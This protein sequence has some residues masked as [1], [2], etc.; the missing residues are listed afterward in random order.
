M[1]AQF[2]AGAAAADI[3]PAHSQFLYGYP[4]VKRY[5]TG[6]HDP[7]RTAAL[8]LTDGITEAMFVSNDI[9]YVPVDVAR[10]IRRGIAQATGVPAEHVMVT[11][12]H[13]HSGPKMGDYLSNEADPAVP[14]ADPRYADY[15]IERAVAVGTEA[16]RNAT[17]ARA[18]LAVADAAGI[19]TNRRDPR[20]PANARAPVLRVQRTDGHDI[21][22]MLVCSMHPTVLH[23]DSTLVSAD[24]P[25]FARR[26]IEKAVL[27]SPC[28]V[29][30]H[31]GPSGNQS[32]RHSV[33]AN[34]FSE[35]QRLGCL[36]GRAV[37]AVAGSIEYRTDLPI[38]CSRKLLRLP[39]RVFPGV[40]Q[41][42]A[43]LGRA[44][45]RLQLLRKDGAPRAV[46]RTAECDWFG[47]EETLALAKAV[48]D[49]RLD[50]VAESV[51]PAE[52]Q[53]ISLGPW[54]FVGWPGEAFIEYSLMATR[55]HD[56]VFI[57]SL[58]NGELQGYIVTPE[59]AEE[60]GYEASNALFAPASGR[61]LVEATR[62]L[63]EE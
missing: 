33:T 49:G 16:R 2:R 32:P 37:E 47:A 24:F 20:G 40:G 25:G 3:T 59:A 8:Y 50:R 7:L 46:V 53:L 41:A 15:L 27:N 19:G 21:A 23:E 1:N 22:L 43:S 14:P 10:R 12:S 35:A 11:A 28:A 18:G 29:L 39:R 17:A 58:A 38:R 4:H 55:G 62:E 5:S 61:L 60:G 26:F 63:I 57:I 51:M 34:T 36:L 56:D 44:I 13:T 45:R 42:Q 48:H 31:T 54:A 30:Y 6:V 52:V 9:I